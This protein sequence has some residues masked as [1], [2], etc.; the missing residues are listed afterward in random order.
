LSCLAL[1]IGGDRCQVNRGRDAGE[2]SHAGSEVGGREP[3]RLVG[4]RA[5]AGTG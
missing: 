5:L 2:T 3:T 4:C 1:V